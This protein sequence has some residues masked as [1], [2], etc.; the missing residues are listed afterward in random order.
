MLCGGAVLAR[1]EE[2]ILGSLWPPWS[3]DERWSRAVE[4]YRSIPPAVC[5]DDME[6]PV[7]NRDLACRELTEAW[8][9][10]LQH[11]SWQ[12]EPLPVLLSPLRGVEDRARGSVVEGSAVTGS[13]P[14]ED[15]S[16]SVC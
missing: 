8:E 2:D 3:A 6:L 16:E 15:G 12:G 4:H 10:L 11:V 5:R 13:A 7:F 14:R 1:L 9:D